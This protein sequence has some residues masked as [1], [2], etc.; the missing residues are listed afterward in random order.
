M[1]VYKL[2]GAGTGGT[3]DGIASL[4]V[5]FDGLITGIAGSLAAELN[6]ASEICQAE[7]SFLSQNTITINDARGSL[8]LLAQQL[9]LFTAASAAP[10][11]VHNAVGGIKVPV[12]AGERIFMHMVATAGV[13][14]IAQIYLFVEDGAAI[15]LRRRR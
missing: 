14:S 2:R 3:Q 5:Q 15:S 8:F 13:V 12:S 7:A 6:A 10:V 9:V 1:S 11:G 4:D